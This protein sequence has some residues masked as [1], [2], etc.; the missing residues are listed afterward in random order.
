[1]FIAYYNPINMI[2]SN[3]FIIIIIAISS[4]YILFCFSYFYASKKLVF[5]P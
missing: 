1:M 5:L 3:V 4:A 2:M